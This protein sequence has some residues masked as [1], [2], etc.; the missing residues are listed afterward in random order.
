MGWDCGK[1]LTRGA[2]L[3]SV[4]E[5][6]VSAF[7]DLLVVIFK[8]RATSRAHTI[9]QKGSG[10]AAATPGSERGIHLPKDRPRFRL[11]PCSAGHLMHFDLIR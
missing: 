2:R 5:G 10:I 1:R 4:L 8:S 7:S 3:V 11:L 6:R 9:V